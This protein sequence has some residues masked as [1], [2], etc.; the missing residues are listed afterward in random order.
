[1]LQNWEFQ[2][3]DNTRTNSYVDNG[4]LHLKPTLLEDRYGAGFVNT[5]TLDMNG[6]SPADE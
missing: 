3:Y 6:G 5:G 4:I 1:M 2:V